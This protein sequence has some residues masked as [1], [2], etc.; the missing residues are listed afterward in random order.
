ND[1]T[2]SN[3]Q[4]FNQENIVGLFPNPV[5]DKF[6]ITGVENPIVSIFSIDGTFLKQ[7]NLSEIDMRNFAQGVYVVRI[8]DDGKI[9]V[10]Q[11][12]K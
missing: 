2:Y 4:I 9:Y 7:V 10:K 6:F 12:V 8:V 3:I 11:I 5:T 1:S